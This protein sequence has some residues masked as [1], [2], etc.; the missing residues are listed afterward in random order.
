[1]ANMTENNT[2][3]KRCPFCGAYGFELSHG[4]V[5]DPLAYWDMGVRGTKYGYVS[6][7]CGAI[8]K[9]LDEGSAIRLWNERANDMVEVVRCK[10]C[11]YWQAIGC[12]G[13]LTGRCSNLGLGTGCDGFCADGREK[14]T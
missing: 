3:L 10:D 12:T 1:M 14:E 8:V 2:A 5:I 11:T 6:C 4:L 7:N 13:E 9:G